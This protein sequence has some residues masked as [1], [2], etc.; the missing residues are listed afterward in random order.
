MKY[1]SESESD[2]LDERS[3]QVFTDD[4]TYVVFPKDGGVEL[5][6]HDKTNRG[7]L[8]FYRGSRLFT[9]PFPN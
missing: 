3:S 5:R 4:A 9:S 7:G 6:I 2:F 1:V 8:S